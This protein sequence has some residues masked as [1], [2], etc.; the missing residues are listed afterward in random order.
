MRHKLKIS[1]SRDPPKMSLVHLQR[2]RV[3]ERFLRLIFGEAR[4]I[5]VIVPGD[6]VKTV[7]IEELPEKGGGEN[8]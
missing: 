4:D 1:V 2:F 7:A 8:E 3:R 6:S 5:A